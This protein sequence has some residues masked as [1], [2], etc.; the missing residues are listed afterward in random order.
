[1]LPAIGTHV[2]T[3][4]ASASAIAYYIRT[5]FTG[6][7]VVAEASVSADTILADVTSAA[8]FLV[9]TVGT[10]F[11]AIR[12]DS[13]TVRASVSANANVIYTELTDTALGTVIALSA[14]AVPTY[15][16]LAAKLIIGTVGTFFSALGTDGGTLRT[17]VS[18]NAN[19]INTV[20]TNAA[21]G[22]VVTLSAYAV[23]TYSTL[24]TKLV[25]GTRLAF[26]SALG[27]YDGTVGASVSA[28]ANVIHTVF[29]NAAFGTVVTLSAYAVPTYSTLR[30]KLVVGTRLTFFSALG[31][32]DGTF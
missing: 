8:Y 23:P 31:A 17:S 30:A 7:T 6:L 26:F 25:V 24:G 29:T 3:F 2:G 5:I 15:S 19:V 32:D 11:S 27:A 13:R 16:T 22:T 9:G 4:R 12:T 1:M 21:F 14:N 28:N 20:F 10:F 18:A